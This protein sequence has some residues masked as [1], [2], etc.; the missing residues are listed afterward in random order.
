METMGTRG[1]CDLWDRCYPSKEVK[2]RI[3]TCEYYG[4]ALTDNYVCEGKMRLSTAVMPTSN[5]TR[6]R[7]EIRVRNLRRNRRVCKHGDILEAEDDPAQCDAEPTKV[8]CAPNKAYEWSNWV[9]ESQCSV[10]YPKLDQQ[11][12]GPCTSGDKGTVKTWWGRSGGDDGS[13]GR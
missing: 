8:L 2:T 3:S 6:K 4:P 11:M 10:C 12:N 1:N 9:A 7:K 5:G 13:M